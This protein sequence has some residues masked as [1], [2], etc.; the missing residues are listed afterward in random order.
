MFLRFNLKKILS[1]DL[2]TLTF[3]REAHP[4]WLS[5]LKAKLQLSQQQHTGDNIQLA[6]LGH[7]NT[8]FEAQ[9]QLS[10]GKYY[11]LEIC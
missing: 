8:V 2:T 7:Q 10:N 6:Y 1:D 4:I 5:L 9:L 3:L 11:V